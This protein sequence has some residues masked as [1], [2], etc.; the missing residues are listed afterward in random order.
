MREG[1]VCFLRFRIRNC[2][3]SQTHKGFAPERPSRVLPK[4]TDTGYFMTREINVFPSGAWR[5]EII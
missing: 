5:R 4:K 3:A 2:I 1:R